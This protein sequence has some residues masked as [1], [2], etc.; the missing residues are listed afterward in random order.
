M[1]PLDFSE[2]LEGRGLLEEW[3]RRR[4]ESVEYDQLRDDNPIFWIVSAFDWSR[5]GGCDWSRVDS[6]WTIEALGYGAAD[7]GAANVVPGMPL[8]DELA[9]RITLAGLEA[10]NESPEL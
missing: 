8:N 5:G 9:L 1:R 4:I 7:A 10:G 3:V 2:W 6:E